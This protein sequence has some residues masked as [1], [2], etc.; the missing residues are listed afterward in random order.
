MKSNGLAV[1]VCIFLTA[2]LAH[3]ANAGNGLETCT[4]EKQF[5][6]LVKT[7]PNLLIIFSKSSK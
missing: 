4:E 3:G 1:F 5:K 6:T 7:K 2:Q